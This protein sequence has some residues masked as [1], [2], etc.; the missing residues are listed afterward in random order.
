MHQNHSV[1][2]TSHKKR[3]SPY[4]TFANTPR[5]K[6]KENMRIRIRGVNNNG[7]VQ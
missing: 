4:T 3:L 7:K 6:E 1:K 2:I 5:N